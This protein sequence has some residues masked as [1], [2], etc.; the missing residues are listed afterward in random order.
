[1]PVRVEDRG[2]V[3]AVALTA[4]ILSR[5]RLEAL[6]A[7]F[8]GL[9]VDPRP[10]LLL[11]DHPRIFLA[12]A[13]LAEI[14]SLTAED[15]AP[16]AALG[17][18]VLERIRSHPRPVVAAVHGPCNGGGFDLALACDGIVAGPDARFVHPGVRRGLV[19]GWGGTARLSAVASDAVCALAMVAARE[20]AAEDIGTYL[21]Q[22]LNDEQL[23]SVATATARRLAAIDGRRL[24]IWRELRA[25]GA[26][27]SLRASVVLTEVLAVDASGHGRGRR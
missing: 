23:A 18:A 7:A 9:A 4:P 12:G 21:I 10:V 1:M 5:Q 2:A 17:R 19:T 8:C 3:V 20:L 25:S 22:A 14:A 16:Y 26:I 24:K 13:D 6:L 11:G 27:D 15:A